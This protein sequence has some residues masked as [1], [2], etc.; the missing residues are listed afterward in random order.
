MHANAYIQTYVHIRQRATQT[1]VHLQYKQTLVRFRRRTTN[2]C[3]LYTPYNHYINTCSLALSLLTIEQSRTQHNAKPVEITPV[4][5]AHAK[6]RTETPRQHVNPSRG[7]TPPPTHKNPEKCRF[8]AL[9]KTSKK[10][11]FANS[12]PVH[13]HTRRTPPHGVGLI[14]GRGFLTAHTPPNYPLQYPNNQKV[15][16]P[17]H[18]K[19][20]DFPRIYFEKCIKDA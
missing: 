3:S 14:G 9:K 15:C 4:R 12:S 18:K 13:P 11:S 10:Y 2:T 19:C 5:I 20:H 6:T 17:M 16:I 1:Y 8:C 7:Y